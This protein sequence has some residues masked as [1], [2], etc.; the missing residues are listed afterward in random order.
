MDS[1]GWTGLKQVFEEESKFL[2]DVIPAIGMAYRGFISAYDSPVSSLG[3]YRDR[4]YGEAKQLLELLSVVEEEPGVLEGI[5]EE[6]VSNF[7]NKVG[8]SKQPKKE[9][10]YVPRLVELT[11][12]AVPYNPSANVELNIINRLLET[13]LRPMQNIIYETVPKSLEKR[14]GRFTLFPEDC[15][16]IAEGASAIE[17]YFDYRCG[18][19]YLNVGYFVENTPVEEL[20]RKFL[21]SVKAFG[22]KW[23]WGQHWDLYPG[24]T[25]IDQFG[26]IN[27]CIVDSLDNSTAS[28][29][30]EAENPADVLLN[31]V[32]KRGIDSA[33][34]RPN[35]YELRRNMRNDLRAN[36]HRE[37]MCRANMIRR[38]G[39][40]GK[41]LKYYGRL[42]SRVKE[43]EDKN[44]LAV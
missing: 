40:L 28:K 15:V 32:P 44:P 25:A 6:D 14:E 31:Y 12:S 42:K 27:L 37:N 9:S 17:A 1:S 18:R 2:H 34:F 13:Y 30:L 3:P 41:F 33:I 8:G 5:H 20:V 23:R 16:K 38:R 26:F 36:A 43:N 19:S 35:R 4:G 24:K 7:E 29:A 10:G 22:H 39:N 11:A 21:P